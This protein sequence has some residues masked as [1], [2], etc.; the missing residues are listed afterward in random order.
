MF[1]FSIVDFLSQ[2]AYQPYAVY[3][4]IVLFMT[5]SSFGLP[6]PEE[7]TLVSAGLIA[8][9][10]RHPDIFPPPTPDAVGVNLTLLS[11]IC[12][13][14]V[15]GSDFL[16][17]TIGRLFGDRIIETKFF[18]RNVGEKRFQKIDKLY[19]KY[20]YWAS[21][22]FRFLPGVRFPGHM[23]CGFMKVPV[24]RFLAV[25]G[26]AA[27]LSVPTQVV[28][29]AFYGEVILSKIKQFKI[30]AAEVIAVIVLLWLSR[31][32]YFYL[33]RRKEVRT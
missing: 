9:M 19:Q 8:Y 25:D 15:L 24:H 4:F 31:K 5:A 17:Y 27:L 33:K 16:I 32:L 10:A 13:I 7:V 21:G 20:G 26:A 11:V 3:G 23:S 1:E 18:K 12:F 29:V 6:I 22:L 28:L 2:Y 14:A 30:I